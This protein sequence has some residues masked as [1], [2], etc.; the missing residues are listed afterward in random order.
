M[1]FDRLP[2]RVQRIQLNCNDRFIPA[3]YRTAR[4][5]WTAACHPSSFPKTAK[6]VFAECA[7]RAN[8]DT[9]RSS[10]RAMQTHTCIF[11][12]VRQA[13]PAREQAWAH[14]M[15][16]RTAGP[17]V[18]STDEESCRDVSVRSYL[19]SRKLNSS[20]QSR[21]EGAANSRTETRESRVTVNEGKNV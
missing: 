2:G 4:T 8:D 20:R 5:A 21:A 7:R 3:D 17:P 13:C 6:L 14:N 1:K 12:R 9:G 10:R 19:L 11:T 18:P 15:N 16:V